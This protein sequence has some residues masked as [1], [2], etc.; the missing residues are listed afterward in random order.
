MNG[1]FD[2][3][4]SMGPARLGAMGAVALGLVAFFAFM[5]MRFN[6]VQMAP[7]YSGLSFEDSSA[8]VKELDSL[9]IPY[10]LREEGKTIL[11][12]DADVLKLRMQLAENGLPTG[13]GV[14]YEIFDKS[15]ALGTTSFV[16][17]VNHLRALEG[18]LGRTIR[19]LD[20]V[21]QA[22]VHLVL[23][24]RQLFKKDAEKPTASVVLKTRGQLETA[25]IR[26]IQHLVASAVPGLQ[27][28]RISIVD[29]TGR[30]LAS[31]EDGDDQG[32]FASNLDERTTSYQ[33]RMENK[34]E[35][36][37]ASVVGPG[38]ARVKVSAELD[39]NRVTQ[40]ED[41]FDPDG[42]VVR[43]SQNREENSSTVN[44]NGEVTVGNQVP[45]GGN[46]NDG[47]SP[48]D[49]TS[50][51]EEVV[52]YEISKTSRTEVVEAGGLKRLS[53][54]VLVDGSY[55]PDAN[56]NMVYSPRTQEE[57][58]RISALVRTAMGYSQDR[59]D[60]I[61]VV[62]LRFA[63]GPPSLPVDGIAPGLFDFDK[64]DIM[65]LAELGVMGVMTLLVLLFAVRPL[66]KRILSPERITEHVAITNQS[67]TMVDE[68]GNIVPLVEG[69]S[70]E[71]TA[72]EAQ[73]EVSRIDEAQAQGE[74]Q[75]VE[76]KKVGKLVDENPI[77]ASIIIRNWL[78]EAA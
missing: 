61:E 17:N 1:L 31:G 29:E 78:L 52:N 35:E 18:E 42:Q 32:L 9:N 19:A 76:I 74:A 59:G 25:Q 28:S 37:I 3:I 13:G 15:D 58:D 66:V 53:V 8:V 46:G 22:R 64:S 40:T 12:A 75:M 51:T 55:A 60:Q 14:G 47:Q 50:K 2:V 30:L 68:N 41:H 70:G 10:E 69:Q 65:R 48:T 63:E 72:I 73:S 56:G 62:N 24:E 11:V 49:Q 44:P 38:R 6:E 39:F 20:R 23:P 4:K 71:L 57:L 54:A 77:E 27:P 26:A 5:I 7:L 33:N 36:I 45:N 21:E 16:Q 67:A 34:I 43:S